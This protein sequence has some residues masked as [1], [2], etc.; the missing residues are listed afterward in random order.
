M[1]RGGWWSTV[2]ALLV[3]Q[4]AA[5][6]AFGG[7]PGALADAAMNGDLSAMHALLK[8]RRRSQRSRRLRHTAAAL[9]RPG[10]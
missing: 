8:K 10:G 1:L 2:M 6:P 7:E 3:V 5:H 9:A 4:A